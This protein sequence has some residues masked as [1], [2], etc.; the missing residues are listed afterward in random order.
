[1]PSASDLLPR[2]SPEHI[3][4]IESGV[5]MAVA[6]RDV[7]NVPSL[8][9]AYG[10]RLSVDGQ[11]LS[12][13]VAR[14]QAASLLRDI[15]QTQVVAVVFSRPSTHETIQIKGVDA[16]I[17]PLRDGDFDQATR[18]TEGLIQDVLSLSFDEH[19]V[20]TLLSF[21]G[22]DLAAIVFTPTAIFAQSPG[23]GAGQRLER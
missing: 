6:S 22:P 4:F 16:L 23:P 7:R 19:G 1:M 9:R 17:Q 10:C 21:A 5:S 18:L 14:T 3:A 20:R 8:A 15:E 2:L 13:F 12:V 11:H